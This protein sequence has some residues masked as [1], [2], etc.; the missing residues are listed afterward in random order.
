MYDTLWIFSKNW[1]KWWENIDETKWNF[2]KYR[3]LYK[4]D[5]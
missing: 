5:N 3:I 1:K 2:D 4:L